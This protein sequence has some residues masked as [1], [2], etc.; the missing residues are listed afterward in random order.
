MEM[1]DLFNENLKSLKKEVKKDTKRWKDIPCL[2]SDRINVH[3][4]GSPNKSF[5]QIHCTVNLNSHDILQGNGKNH[6]KIH[7]EPQKILR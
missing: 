5:L 4:N 2:W 1:K 6:H 3:E 7:I